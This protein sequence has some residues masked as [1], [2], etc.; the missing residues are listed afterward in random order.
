M[1]NFIAVVACV[2][3][4]IVSCKTRNNQ[5][6]SSSKVADS[7]SVFYPDSAIVEQVE[8]V[9][10]IDEKP[11]DIDSVLQ[12]NIDVASRISVED[13]LYYA[14]GNKAFYGDNDTG[15][16]VV[17]TKFEKEN[18]VIAIVYPI[19]YDDEKTQPS[20]KFYELKN[21]NWE[22]IQEVETS[23]ISYFDEVD[24]DNDGINEIQAIGYPN[25]NGNYSNYFYS[26]SKKENKFIDGG[27]FFSAEYKFIPLKSRIE[28]YY[29]L[30][31]WYMPESKTIYYWKNHK[32]IPYKE[33]EVGLKI[34]DMRHTAE[35]IKYSEN[36]NLDKDSL[37]LKFKKT[38]RGKKLNEFYDKFFENN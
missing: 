21:K 26:Y 34:A 25:M 12:A 6:N 3:F 29:V 19:T 31:S 23:N 27:G 11:I 4:V 16:I 33:V 17:F 2:L 10:E 37:E 13:T 18:N 9:K 38:F 7:V 14:L 22:F 15:Q 36:L 5:V 20:I 1:K 30:R 24:L 8:I 28:V 35:Y 32:L